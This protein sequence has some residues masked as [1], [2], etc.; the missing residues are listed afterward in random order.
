MFTFFFIL[1]FN[2][3]PMP[4]LWSQWENVLHDT[5]RC[6]KCFSVEIRRVLG[7]PSPIALPWNLQ[8]VSSSPPS[9]NYLVWMSRATSSDMICFASRGIQHGVSFFFFFFNQKC[10][11]ANDPILFQRKM[12]KLQWEI[13]PQWIL[14]SY[15]LYT[16]IT[17][18]RTN[19]HTHTHACSTPKPCTIN[20][21][22]KIKT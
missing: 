10:F 18:L 7:C 9:N 15:T 21:G 22:R 5:T 19:T 1:F 3:L 13:V 2:I 14:N 20:E 11:Q 12:L 8:V 6:T 17:Q 4:Q 16:S